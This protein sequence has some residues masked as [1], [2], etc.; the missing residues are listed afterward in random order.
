MSTSSKKAPFIALIVATAA[1]VGLFFAPASF[2]TP[3]RTSVRD[4]ILPGHQ[5]VSS[6]VEST[7]TVAARW[8][9]SQTNVIEFEKSAT[10]S[11]EHQLQ[12]RQ[13][14][15]ANARLK[16][17]LASQKIIGVSPYQA[18]ETKPLLIDG[19]IQATVFGEETATLWKAGWLLDKGTGDGVRKTDL[20]LRDKGPVVDQGENQQLETG[21]PIFAGRCVYGRI[22]QVGRW[23]S[24]VQRVTDLAY[25]GHARIVRKTAN[26]YFFGAEGVLEGTGESICRLKL[27]TA[28][29]PVA[30]GD[31]VYTA[32][33]KDR[34][35]FSM[36]YG[37]IV[38]AELP[39][40]ATHWEIDVQPAIG[41]AR[42][43]SVQILRQR[44]NPARGDEEIHR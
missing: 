9:G 32:T 37:K 10:L 19:L 41:N 3:I 33:R 43:K 24:S 5:A 29:M 13:L 28:E 25:R 1:A 30:V 40:G 23:T 31:D 2:T 14:Q 7:Q 8:T 34:F 11:A 35:P 44:L 20:V 18:A 4:A 21:F 36:Y 12:I 42:P 26:G 16:Q 6:V 17:Q 22:S 27:I 39:A 15:I 38:R